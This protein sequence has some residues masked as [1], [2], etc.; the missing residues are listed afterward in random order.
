MKTTTKKQ[1]IEGLKNDL[2]DQGID[3][4][5]YSNG[6]F[7]ARIGFFYTHGKSTLDLIKKIE[8]VVPDFDVIDSGEVWKSFNGGASLRASSHWFVKFSL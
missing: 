7:T 2:L 1:L 8:A 6:I 5:A 4:V 3:E